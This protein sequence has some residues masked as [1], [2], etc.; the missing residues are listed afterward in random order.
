MIY[1]AIAVMLSSLAFVEL[2]KSSRMYSVISLFFTLIIFVL[3]AGLRNNVG[4]DWV[5]YIDFYHNVEEAERVEI[6]YRL[7]N[8]YFSGL[9]VSYT[10]FLLSINL[11]ALILM[12]YFI[13]NNTK[14]MLL[15]SLLFFCD[16]YLYYNLSGIRQAIAISITCYSITYVINRQFFKFILAV[17]LAS[18]FHASALVFIFIYYLPVGMPSFK[19][20]FVVIILFIIGFI[21]QENISEIITLYNIKDATFYVKNQEN[22]ISF[23]DYIVGIVKRSILV[24]VLFLYGRPFFI[25]KNNWLFTNIYLF[26]LI[27][28][29]CTYN[30]S[31]DIGVRLSSYFTIFEIIIVG[32]L[33]CSIRILSNRVFI[34]SIYIC[35]ALFKINS[36]TNDQAYIYKMSLSFT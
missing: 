36:Y 16:L 35:V 23:K 17:L 1:F 22:I 8:N 27:I 9:S 34:F 5:S 31:P 2:A 4:A 32:R 21:F 6:G 26:G 19:F 29:I 3:I 24:L 7:L 13:K 11:F 25:N 10:I 30:I 20:I 12:F 33:I 28:Y 18:F 14:L 15:A